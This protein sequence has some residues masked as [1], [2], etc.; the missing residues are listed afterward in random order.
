MAA[1]LL[2]QEFYPISTLCNNLDY[3]IS[4]CVLNSNLI[5]YSILSDQIM[6]GV[7]KLIQRHVLYHDA[8]YLI[9]SFKVIVS[10]FNPQ[11]AHYEHRILLHG[12]IT[13]DEK[14]LRYDLIRADLEE[15]IR[16]LDYSNVDQVQ[17][18]V[19]KAFS[20]TYLS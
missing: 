13:T 8:K 4:I 7:E 17:E 3:C 11:T 6:T 2:N 10:Y 19:M 5:D 15:Q 9:V 20:I 16:L 18:V 12:F 1:I 14:N